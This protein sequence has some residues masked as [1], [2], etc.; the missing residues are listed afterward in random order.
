MGKAHHCHTKCPHA[1]RSPLRRGEHHQSGCRGVDLG[2]RVRRATPVLAVRQGV[3]QGL[4]DSSDFID[5]C[6][7]SG[8]PTP[9]RVRRTKAG[10]AQ[11]NPTQPPPPTPPKLIGQIFLAPSAQVSLGQKSLFG[12]FGASNNSGSLEGG[13]G[14]RPHSPPPTPPPL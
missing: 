10:R 13:M 3:L 7:A 14:G 8:G 4:P 12:A 5:G 2:Q 9:P 6:A 11:P 1:P